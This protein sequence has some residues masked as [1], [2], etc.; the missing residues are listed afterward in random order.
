MVEETNLNTYLLISSNIFGI[1][2]FDV[3]KSLYI[4]KQ[5]IKIDN[6]T[7][8]IDLNILSSFLEDNVF[9]IEKLIKKFLKNI[10]LIVQTEG[11]NEIKII[12]F[13]KTLKTL[14]CIQYILNLTNNN[15]YI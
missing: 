4:Y 2:L 8:T 13:F 12:H 9:K 11:N 7:S 5:E 6:K 3:K 15:Y 14:F 10:C 1:Y